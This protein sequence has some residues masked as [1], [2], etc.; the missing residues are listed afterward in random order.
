MV[1]DSSSTSGSNTGGWGP[2]GMADSTAVSRTTGN[3]HIATDFGG[4]RMTRSFYAW[5]TLILAGLSISLLGQACGVTQSGT[6]TTDSDTGA[7]APLVPDDPLAPLVPDEPDPLAPLTTAR[8][9]CGVWSG[10]LAGTRDRVE[11]TH[12]GCPWSDGTIDLED[13]RTENQHT[14]DVSVKFV[15]VWGADRWG[16]G[17]TCAP[18]GAT[19]KAAATDGSVQY[20]HS[21][22]YDHDWGD[23]CRSHHSTTDDTFVFNVKG[24]N[25]SATIEVY[26]RPYTYTEQQA[27]LAER[28]CRAEYPIRVQIQMS[29]PD[30]GG[31]GTHHWTDRSTDVCPA[32][33]GCPVPGSVESDGSED[34]DSNYGASFIAILYGTYRI[35]AN[36]YD[37]IEASY[38]GSSQ[39][40]PNADGSCSGV[41]EDCAS[42][43]SDMLSEDYTLTLTR[44]PEG[45]RDGDL[46]C[47]SVDPCPDEAFEESCD[48][49]P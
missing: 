13:D 27:I 22:T 17:T 29:S 15:D 3:H 20:T 37:T 25:L 36:G 9:A 32:C 30:S 18:G 26:P 12:T 14:F 44:A 2:S 28:P 35:D 11:T 48:T 21:Y 42:H 10:K 24:E 5:T 16:A 7:L 1:N 49:A 38:K 40:N 45:D 31:A 41:N 43:C 8:G 6:G 47:D 34:V 33:D 23:N 46:I 19:E 39:A 4:D